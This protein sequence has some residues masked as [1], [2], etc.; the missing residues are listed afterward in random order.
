MSEMLTDKM[1]CIVEVLFEI[2]RAAVRRWK[3][4]VREAFLLEVQRDV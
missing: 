4:F 2:L 1:E 3:S